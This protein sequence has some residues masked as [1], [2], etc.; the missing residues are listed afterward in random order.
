MNQLCH[1]SDPQT[2]GKGDPSDKNEQ[3]KGIRKSTRSICQTE[4]AG[5]Q[6]S[7][8][9]IHAPIE[10]DYTELE[11]R[12]S[13][14]MTDAEVQNREKQR[15]QRNKRQ[16]CWQQKRQ[17]QK[18]EASE[19]RQQIAITPDHDERQQTAATAATKAAA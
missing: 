10:E 8:G 16:Q 3:A 7:A 14:S 5:A 6:R 15:R 17:Q 4:A 12:L 9:K 13:V 19:A 11:E 2:A 1:T 18:D